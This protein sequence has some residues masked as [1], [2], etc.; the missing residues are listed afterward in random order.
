MAK[1]AI[2]NASNRVRNSNTKSG[3]LFAPPCI[4]LNDYRDGIFAGMPTCIA[5]RLSAGPRVS[6]ANRDLPLRGRHRT[7]AGMLCT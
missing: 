2:Y 6:T 7:T 4:G 5:W 1:N 3:P